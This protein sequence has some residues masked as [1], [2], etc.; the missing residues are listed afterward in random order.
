MRD[1]LLG[2]ASFVGPEERGELDRITELMSSLGRQKIKRYLQSMVT[3]HDAIAAIAERSS[4]HANG[5]V[6]IVLERRAGM[7]ARLHVWNA[8]SEPDE[9]PPGNIHNHVWGFCSRVLVGALEEQR[10][11]VDDVGSRMDRYRY[12]AGRDSVSRGILEP[13]GVARL[14]ESAALS[15]RAGSLYRIGNSTLHRARTDG[16]QGLGVTFAITGSRRKA[17]TSVFAP[18]GDA[19][20]EDPPKRIL[21]PGEVQSLLSLVMDAI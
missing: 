20:R 8:I 21:P 10:F 3:D 15:H 7:A 17:Y 19:I 1:G 11:E 4:M 9:S 16:E 14:G 18:S 12:F 13:A 5:F 6:K 2:G